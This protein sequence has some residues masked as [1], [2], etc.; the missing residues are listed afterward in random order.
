MNLVSYAPK[1]LDSLQNNAWDAWG[2]REREAKVSKT[3]DLP[4]TCKTCSVRS[5]GRT[6]PKARVTLHTQLYCT[7]PPCNYKLEAKL[8]AVIPTILWGEVFPPP[9]FGALRARRACNG[10]EGPP[11]ERSE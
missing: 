9:V 2:A 11:R 6:M 8:L 4:P 3:M 1:S 10:H 7:M 5:A